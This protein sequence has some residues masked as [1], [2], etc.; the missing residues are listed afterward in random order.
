MTACLLSMLHHYSGTLFVAVC[1]RDG[2]PKM[3][4]RSI[5]QTTPS[6]TKMVVGLT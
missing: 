2:L 5:G 3:L 1:E 6:V 4:R